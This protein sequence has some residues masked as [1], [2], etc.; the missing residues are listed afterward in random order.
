MIDRCW[1]LDTTE[2]EQQNIEGE[3]IC[4]RN[5]IFRGKPSHSR[6]EWMLLKT[7]LLVTLVVQFEQRNLADAYNSN[8]AGV[9]ASI[10]E[11]LEPQDLGTLHLDWTPIC[12]GIGVHS[13]LTLS[14]HD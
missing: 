7:C 14:D 5:I 4:D 1:I 12:P 6:S 10:L 11:P 9:G 8:R 3:A 13:F 2:S